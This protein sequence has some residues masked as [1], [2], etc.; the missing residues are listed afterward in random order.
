M[1]FVEVCLER[2]VAPQSR[3]N[4]ALDVGIDTI[5]R[6]RL[7]FPASE[8]GPPTHILANATIFTNNAG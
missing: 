5:E 4:H 1:F 2:R 6:H 3:Y 7:S 8:L